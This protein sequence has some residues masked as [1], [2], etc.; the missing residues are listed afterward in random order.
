MDKRDCEPCLHLH[1]GYVP[2]TAERL[3]KIKNIYHNDRSTDKETS[4]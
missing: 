4:E 1:K 2:M 3:Q